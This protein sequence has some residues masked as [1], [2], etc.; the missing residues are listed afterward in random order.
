LSVDE[1]GKQ[2][3][4]VLTARAAEM[5]SPPGSAS[6]PAPDLDADS[7]VSER[8]SGRRKTGLDEPWFVLA[9]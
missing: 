1:S 2:G 6:K 7:P 5:A 4:V 9:D 8:K 3:F